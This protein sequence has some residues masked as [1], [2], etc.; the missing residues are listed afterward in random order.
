MSCNLKRDDMKP[1]ARFNLGKKMKCTSANQDL[2]EMLPSDIEDKTFAWGLTRRNVSIVCPQAYNRLGAM[3]G[4][5]ITGLKIVTSRTAELTEAAVEMDVPVA[6][7]DPDFTETMVKFMKVLPE[8]KNIKPFPRTL[9]PEGHQMDARRRCTAYGC[10]GYITSVDSQGKEESNILT[11]RSKIGKKSVPGHEVLSANQAAE[12]GKDVIK[13]LKDRP[14][15][16]EASPSIVMAGDSI[17]V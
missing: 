13:A 9:I 12:A 8:S 3:L 16:Q 10:V 4:P 1:L 17:Y 11:A 6:K 14:Q 7:K 15:I 5:I 2:M